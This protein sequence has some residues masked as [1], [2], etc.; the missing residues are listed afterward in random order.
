MPIPPSSML[1]TTNKA[2]FKQ[3][4]KEPLCVMQSGSFLV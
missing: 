4:K 2:P 3:L 1:P